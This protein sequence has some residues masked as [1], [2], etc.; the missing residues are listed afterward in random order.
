[1]NDN[2]RIHSK[3]GAMAKGFVRSI[4]ILFAGMWQGTEGLSLRNVRLSRLI[5]VLAYSFELIFYAFH[6]TFLKVD[7]SL[8]GIGSNMLMYIGHILMSLIIMLLWSKRFKHLVYISIVTTALGFAA[9]QFSPGGLPKLLCAVLTMAGLGGC[10]T[11]ARCG[12]AFAANNAERLLGVVTALGGR[13]VLNFLDAALPDGS[14]GDDLLFMYVYPIAA[15]EAMAYC[16]LRFKEDD[17]EVKEQATSEDK[18]GLYW[19]FCI[20]IVF[21]AVEGYKSLAGSSSA[22]ASLFVGIGQLAA[23]VLFVTVLVLLKKSVWHTWNLFLV[24]AIV[25]AVLTNL[26]STPLVEASIS[27]FKGSFELGWMSV[28]FLLGCAQRRHASLKLLKKCT[29]VFVAVSPV[30]TLSDEIAAMLFPEYIPVFTLVFVLV[31]VIGLLLASPSSYKYLFSTTWL[32]ELSERDMELLME[33]VENADIVEGLALTPREKEIFVFL[34]TDAPAKII[35]AEMGVSVAT[36]NFHTKNLYRKLNI[37]S[38]A[39]LF[40]QYGTQ[41]PTSGRA[42]K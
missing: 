28:L 32:S 30:T 18:K 4:G 5:Y 35:S 31:V 14:F 7:F 23:I 15:L 21:F 13:M 25:M 1:M 11:S 20:F 26:A 16:L 38:R 37:Q 39:E 41:R 8:F 36:V 2:V 6:K 27:I 17:L 9:F 12:F 22:Q 40:V 19:A 24:V 34:L 3:N 42:Y 33:K 29:V 10:V